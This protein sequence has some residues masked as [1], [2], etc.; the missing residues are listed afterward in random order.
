MQGTTVSVILEKDMFT[1]FVNKRYCPARWIRSKLGSFERYLL[2]GEA[3]RLL[4]KS[5]RPP[6]C[7]SPLKIQR[8][9][10][11]YLAI[12]I[13]IYNAMTHTAPAVSSIFCIVQGLAKAR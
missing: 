11:Q 7:E 12:M 13:L 4:E 6:S 9:L 10:V 5:A 3:P 2:K 1:N 8:H